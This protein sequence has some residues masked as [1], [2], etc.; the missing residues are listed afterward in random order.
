MTRA[1]AVRAAG[2]M[3]LTGWP[4]LAFVCAFSIALI[5]VTMIMWNR[6]PTGW[7][8]APRQGCLLLLMVTG[9][10]LAADVVNREFGFYASF[11]DL[12][13]RLPSVAV[14]PCPGRSRGTS[15]GLVRGRIERVR[16][17]GSVSGISRDALVDLRA[18]YVAPAA[19]HGHFP[20]IGLFWSKACPTAFE[21]LVGHLPVPTPSLSPRDLGG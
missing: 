12:L 1:D 7:A 17:T 3:T 19:V 15:P 16:P 20:V 14:M 11:D 5:S 21:W 6:W 13:G 18:A 2:A 8:L 9:A 4:L 10:I